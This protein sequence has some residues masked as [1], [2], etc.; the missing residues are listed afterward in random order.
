[1]S[2]SAYT[3]EP[4]ILDL[5]EEAWQQRLDGAEKWLGNLL[6][7][8]R[9]FRTL[10]EDTAGKLTEP[11]IR[12]YVG[13]LAVEA[14]EQERK[15]ERLFEVIGRKPPRKMQ[16]AGSVVGKVRRTAADLQGKV[17]GAET[18]WRDLHQ[19][20]LANVNAMG[21]FAIAEQLGLAL[22]L[23]E[24]VDITFPVVQE[25]STAQLLIQELLLETAPPAILSAE[26]P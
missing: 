10:A 11:H 12:D 2:N 7:T 5:G 22:G 21:A 16:V 25:L 15:A 13:D 20:L 6:M 4:I 24:I 9:A 23:P 1:V 8:Q 17:G 26:R 14:K 3:G 18:G 19:L